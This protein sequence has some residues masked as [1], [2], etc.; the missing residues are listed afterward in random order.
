MHIQNWIHVVCAPRVRECGIDGINVEERV[1]GRERVE[2]RLYD[3]ASLV[4]QQA[5]SS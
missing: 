2:A 5:E 4:G 3:G 1:G